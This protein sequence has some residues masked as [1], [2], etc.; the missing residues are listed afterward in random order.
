MKYGSPSF[1]VLLV[2]GYN[3]LSAKVQNVS[4]KTTNKV[5]ANTH[6]LGDKW[7][8]T[9]ATGVL[10]GTVTQSGAFFDDAVAGMH[11]ALKAV[12]TVVRLLVYALA[13]NLIGQP[14]TG[15]SGVYQGA[16]SILAKIGALTLADAEYAVAGQVDRGVIV[17]SWIQKLASWNTFTDGFPVDVTLDPT[18]IAIPIVSNSLANPTVITTAVPHRLTTGDVVLH[19]GVAG[20][21]PTINGSFTATVIDAT[22]Y[23]VPVNV[24]IAGTGG[25]FVRASSNNG[26]VGYQLVSQYAGITGFVG[27][28]RSSADNITYADLITF[29]N[30]T[31]A[32]P[33][34]SA[35]QRLT[36]TGVIA[37]WLC[38]TGTFT[39]A[40]SITPFAGFKRNAPQ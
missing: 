8:E 5:Q 29:A 33:D 27:K 32:P 3:L 37:R 23:S 38:F 26:G 6:G 36:V 7:T 9:S 35:A 13:G 14:F 25:Q 31:A 2:D 24:T 39:G 21:T 1:S 20:S 17:Q 34:A 10:A 15:F 40:G 16:Y 12:T 11:E 4:D 22:H 18:N 28:I 30:V 19:S